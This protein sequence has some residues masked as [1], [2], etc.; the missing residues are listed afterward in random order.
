[1]ETTQVKHN[2]KE[3]QEQ[4]KITQPKWL[5]IIL[6]CI[7]GYEAAGCLLG[8]SLL[9]AK[10][11]GRLM[12]MPVEIMHGVFNDFL[13][14]GII[15]FALGILNT[16][17]FVAVLRRSRFDWVMTG[18][19]MGGLAIWF[20]IEIAILEEL[21]WL[22]AMWGLPVALGCLLA[23]AFFSS[24]DTILKVLLVCGILSSLLYVAIN[25][26]VPT[27]WE[28]YNSI[29]QTVSELSAIDAPT[30]MLWLVLST[31]YTLFIIAFAWGVWKS[32]G[33][34]RPLRFAGIL[35]FIYGVVNVMW[36]FAPMHQREALA[37]GEESFSDTMHL[38]IASVTVALMLLAMGF[39]AAAFGKR[40]RL[41]SIITMLMLLLFGILTA[42][43]APDVQANL[44]TPYAGIWERINIGVFLL[45]VIVLSIKLL[46]SGK[47]PNHVNE[48]R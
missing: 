36:P 13:V 18:L 2:T 4:K 27:Q 21:H 33:E 16:L 41:Y 34:N 11:D 28:D 42:L 39:G 12:D 29:S 32:A 20:W 5:R 48:S 46:Q 37:A 43:D 26:I 10:P 14:P 25:I 35:L 24:R 47:N 23:I 38:I 7:I 3:L 9:I 8:G 15:L 44:P 40:F 17:A 30:R 6:L 1:M 22:H 19:G 45:W 31:P